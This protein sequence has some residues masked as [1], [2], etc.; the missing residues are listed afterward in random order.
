MQSS[1]NLH[2]LYCL[3]VSYQ[4][5][6]GEGTIQTLYGHCNVLGQQCSH[7]ICTFK[8]IH[9]LVDTHSHITHIIMAV[10]PIHE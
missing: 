2:G 3:T 9:K 8:N 7:T 5:K 4:T 6:F 1:K 10:I